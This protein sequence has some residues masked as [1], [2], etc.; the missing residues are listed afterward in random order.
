MKIK[1]FSDRVLPLGVMG[2]L[3]FLLAASGVRFIRSGEVSSGVLDAFSET[4][5]GGI[6]DGRVQEAWGEWFTDHF[7]GH[8]AAVSAHNQISYSLFGDASGNWIC[9]KDWYLFSAG[10][11]EK[12]IQVKEE[13]WTPQEYDDY[14]KKV[15]KMQTALQAA[16]KE[17]VYILTPNKVEIYPEQ[18][19]W[20]HRFILEHGVDEAQGG[21]SC[22]TEAFDR[23]G[24]H[25]YDCTQ[26]LL[27][28]KEEADFD[29]F[30]RTGHHWTLTACAQEMNAI[31][32]GIG[33]ATPGIAYPEIE[34]VG[35]TDEIC[36]YDLDILQ[37]QKVW[38]GHNKDV[39]YQS[40]LIAYPK[41]SETKVYWFGTS[42]G[43]LFTQAMYQGIDARAF[44]RLVF[45]QY[46]T[47]LYSFDE[48]GISASEFTAEDTPEDI[49]V[50]DNIWNNDL[51]IMEQQ[52]DSGVYPTHV[53]FVDYVNACLE[54]F[55]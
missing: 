3:C 44:K 14:A 37:A 23:N 28:I 50:M 9:G 40:P 36:S 20:Y 52:A 46:F 39:H 5:T 33:P 21:H 12:Y 6:F 45:Q 13:L 25:Y 1:S 16:G 55:N 2:L 49:G 18:L 48:K 34:V 11:V 31:F 29:A 35:I 24:V 4:G 15:Y 51:I 42:Y 53:K 47:G 7:F 17:F 41:M 26:D 43:A 8:S 19:P 10:Q 30:A 32:A 38:F 27:R 22:L 54:G